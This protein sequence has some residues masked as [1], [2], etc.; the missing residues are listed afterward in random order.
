MVVPDDICVDCNLTGL[1]LAV[2]DF[3]ICPI[4]DSANFDSTVIG[5]TGLSMVLSIRSKEDHAVTYVLDSGFENFER[6]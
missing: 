4:F 1:E 2:S 3:F 5:C 6:C